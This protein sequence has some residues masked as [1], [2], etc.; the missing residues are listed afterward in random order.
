MLFRF[1][2]R[3]HHATARIAVR[4]SEGR[5]LIFAAKQRV[6]IDECTS[7]AASDPAFCGKI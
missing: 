4:A 6:A 3:I 2:L 1:S 5:A 7:L